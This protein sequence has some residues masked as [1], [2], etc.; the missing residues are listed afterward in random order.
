VNILCCPFTS[1]TGM[2]EIQRDRGGVTS[3]KKY[4]LDEN[5]ETSAP[6]QRASPPALEKLRIICDIISHMLPVNGKLTAVR[7]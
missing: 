6:T 3:R 2:T 5:Q 4:R 7:W 1:Q